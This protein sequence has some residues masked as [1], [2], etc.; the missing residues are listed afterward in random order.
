M[1]VLDTVGFVTRPR[2]YEVAMALTRMRGV[3]L[4]PAPPEEED[5][6]AAVVAREVEERKYI[7]AELWANRR[8][9]KTK[10]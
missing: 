10:T 8:T 6:E 1:L 4:Q 5:E 9:T 2:K 3:T 7:I